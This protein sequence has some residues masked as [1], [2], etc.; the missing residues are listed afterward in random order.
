MQQSLCKIFVYTSCKDG[1]FFD[2]CI[3]IY[4]ISEKFDWPGVP[5][6]V[7]LN[8]HLSKKQKKT[9]SRHAIILRYDV[10]CKTRQKNSDSSFY[11]E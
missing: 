6:N 10:F 3:D 5:N 8:L 1:P 9:V 11:S 4:Q 7:K 2:K